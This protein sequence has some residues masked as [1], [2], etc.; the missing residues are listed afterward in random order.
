MQLPDETVE[1]LVFSEGFPVRGLFES[2]V[3]AVL[4]VFCSVGEQWIVP[5]VRVLPKL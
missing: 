3:K 1:K 5:K 2:L 4:Q